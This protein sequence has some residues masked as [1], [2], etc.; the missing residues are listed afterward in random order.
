MSGEWRSDLERAVVAKL[1][2][3]TDFNE[4]ICAV[5]AGPG[6]P[7]GP[8]SAYV[9]FD[10]WKTE[11]VDGTL[12]SMRT[13]GRATFFVNIAVTS[14]NSVTAGARLNAGGAYDLAHRA[15]VKLVGHEPALSGLNDGSG[16]ECIWP[17]HFDSES[18]FVIPN[19]GVFEV[20]QTYS[21]QLQIHSHQS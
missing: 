15:M 5:D 1:R 2:E 21:I 18:L 13:L 12:G 4:V 11:Q 20:E 9:S 17:I 8:K 16:E 10:G 7:Q 6:K 19:G 3:I 14:S